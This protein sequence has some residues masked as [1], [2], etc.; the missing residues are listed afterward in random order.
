MTKLKT[1]IGLMSGT[2]MDGIDAALMRTDGKKQVEIIG[3]HQHVYPDSFRARLKKGLADAGNITAPH[4]RPGIL[5]QLEKTLTLH[6]ARLVAKFIT[7]SGFDGCKIDLIGFHGQTVLHRPQQ[8]LTVQIGDGAL[9]AEKTGIDVI[10]DMRS[11]DIGHG[12]E[13]APLIPVY[14]AALAEKLK[15]KHRFPLAF[16][17]IGGIANLTWIDRNGNLTA[18]DCGPGNCLIDQWVE[19][20]TGQ[21]FDRHGK[22]GLKGQVNEEIA[23]HYLNLPLFGQKK[24][25]SFDWRDFPP[26]KKKAAAPDDGAATLAYVTAAAI[27]NSFKNLPKKPKTLI[28]CGGGVRN[29]AIMHTLTRLADTEGAKVL[30]AGDIG[31]NAD[32]IEAEAWGYLAVRSFYNLPLTYPATTGCSMPVSG[33]VLKH[34]AR[35]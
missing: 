6:H 12:G 23:G 33:G 11:N 16:V 35:E 29:Q 4:E 34:A 28:V 31:L 17:N 20:H 22:A 14:H 27:V 2:S 9:L 24:R 7:R 25:R 3:H 19:M 30:T 26:L 5:R 8:Q 13:G 1:V 21:R 10:Y 15:G 32:F 18:F